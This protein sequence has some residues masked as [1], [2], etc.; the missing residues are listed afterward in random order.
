MVPQQV[1]W[2]RAEIARSTFEAR[3]TP[4]A[5]LVVDDADVVRYLAPPAQTVYPLEYAYSL[6]GDVRGRVV[7]D[8]GCG[9]GENSLLL[10]RRGATVIGVDISESLI[11][12]ARR[13]LEVNGVAGQV[14]FVVGSAHDLPLLEGSVDVVLWIAILHHL[15]L[16]AASREVHR[17]LKPGGRA[18]FKEPVRDSKIVRAVRRC[19]PYRAPDISPFERPLTTPEV[20]RFSARF[21]S[22][23]IRAFSLP[24]VNL[25]R[26]I[27]PLKSYVRAACRLDGAALARVPAL[28]SFSTIRV[29]ELTK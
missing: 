1:E 22:S 16:D 19:I 7:V 6:L 20:K 5:R 23:K 13:R 14:Q 24:F 18:I 8:F 11:E 25:I 27:G 28:A 4:A 15:D 12:L 17:I 9:S 21:R 26:A 10:A 3:H 2:E 29:F